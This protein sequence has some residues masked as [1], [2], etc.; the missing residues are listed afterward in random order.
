MITFSDAVVPIEWFA[1]IWLQSFY[2]FTEQG[3]EIVLRETAESD[4]NGQVKRLAWVDYE[5]ELFFSESP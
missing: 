1:L 3:A 5:F 2:L 4:N